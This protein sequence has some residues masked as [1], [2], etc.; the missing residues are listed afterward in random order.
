MPHTHSPHFNRSPSGRPSLRPFPLLVNSGTISKVGDPGTQ[1]A[2][3][4]PS[5]AGLLVPYLPRVSLEWLA[6]A[7]E[8]PPRAPEGALAFVDVSRFPAMSER[9]APLAARGAGGGTG[10]R[11]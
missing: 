6:A 7:A 11:R 10:P 1:A 8:A 3:A 5:A 4:A 9:L 2:E